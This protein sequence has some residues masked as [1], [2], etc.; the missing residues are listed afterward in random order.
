MANVWAALPMFV[1]LGSSYA[2]WAYT[3][4]ATTDDGRP[5]MS[6]CLD[7][8]NSC[9]VD[10]FNNRKKCTKDVK[11][12]APRFHTTQHV[13]NSQIKYCLSNCGHFGEEYEWCITT[14]NKKWDYCNSGV[15]HVSVYKRKCKGPCAKHKEKYYWCYTSGGSWQICAPPRE[16]PGRRWQLTLDDD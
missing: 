6:D 7:K 4:E 5:C 2:Q 14:N 9:Y 8:D 13:D 3:I 1:L 16:S 10:W 15:E 11:N 12:V